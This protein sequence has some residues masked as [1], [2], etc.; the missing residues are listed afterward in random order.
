MIFV[1]DHRDRLHDVEQ[2]A[3]RELGLKAT[4]G[5]YRAAIHSAF[6]TIDRRRRHGVRWWAILPV[7]LS[8]LLVF[9]A[10]VL[11]VVYSQ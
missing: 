9:A 4:S 3:R 10:V 7:A 8:L 5:D 2:R 6:A 1:D 11:L